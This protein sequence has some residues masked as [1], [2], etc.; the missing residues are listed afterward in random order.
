M[1]AKPSAAEVAVTVTPVTLSVAACSGR[2]VE[3]TETALGAEVHLCINK[4]MIHRYPA[5]LQNLKMDYYRYFVPSVVAIGPYHHGARHLQEAE[6]IKWSAVCDFC[7]NTGH[8][9]DEV[10]WKI[11]PIASGARSCYEGDA[12][13]GVRK[14]EFAAMMIRDGC[15]LLQFMAHMCD[16]A[17]DPLLQTWFGSKQPSILRDMFMLENQIPWVV[18]E[19]LM[20]FMPVP[21]PVDNFISNAGASFNVR[22]DDN[23]NPFDLNEISCKPHLLGLLRYYQSGLSKLGESSW[24]LKRPEG[25]TTALRQSSSAIELAEIGIDVVATEA[26]WFADMKISKGLLFGKLSMPPLVM[27][28]LNACWL[29][30]MVALESYLAFTGKN[31]VQTVSSYISLLAMLMNR[32]EEVHELRLKGIL[33]GKFSDKCTLSFLKNLA[34]LISLPPQHVCLLAHLEAYQRKRWMWIPIHKFLYNN[35]RII[36]T[37]FSVIGV[38]VGIFKTLVSIEQQMQL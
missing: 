20:T 28:D 4:I 1:A 13:V 33:H 30:N 37:V 24:V 18:L 38:L 16:V 34:G 31:D 19:A 26:S 11:L 15:F 23:I 27:D 14:A 7:K 17:V 35:Y 32:K 25:V 36:V 3:S 22:L 5:I 10:Y 12:V 21:V 2:H 9:A 8:S 29:L 6:K